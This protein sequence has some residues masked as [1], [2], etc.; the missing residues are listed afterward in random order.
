M[1]PPTEVRAGQLDE[2]TLLRSFALVH[3]RYDRELRRVRAALVVGDTIDDQDL[4]VLERERDMLFRI[5]QQSYRRA[6]SQ[7]R[8]LP[9]Q[10]RAIGG[11]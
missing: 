5:W 3:E 2:L 8:I 1:T 9:D 10:V 6:G 4:L 7:P 11:L